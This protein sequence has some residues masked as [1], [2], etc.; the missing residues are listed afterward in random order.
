MGALQWAEH[1]GRKPENVARCFS[2]IRGSL[3]YCMVAELTDGRT[4]R[5]IYSRPDQAVP[6][7]VE[8]FATV[9]AAMAEGQKVATTLAV[10]PRTVLVTDSE[11]IMLPHRH[12]RAH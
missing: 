4:I 7:V 10:A 1:R 2:L 6:V 8:G 9:D 12:A 11:F 3:A 5:L